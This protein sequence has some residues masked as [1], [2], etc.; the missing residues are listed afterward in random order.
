LT[1]P[2]GTLNSEGI[3]R[4][5]TGITNLRRNVWDRCPPATWGMKAILIPAGVQVKTNPGESDRRVLS[6][7]PASCRQN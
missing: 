2:T 4:L 7:I 3:L 5:S 1:S 6:D